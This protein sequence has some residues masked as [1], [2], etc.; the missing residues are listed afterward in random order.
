MMNNLNII[1]Y[2]I[3]IALIIHID[4]LNQ[5]IYVWLMFQKIFILMKMIIFIKNVTVNV[6]AAQNMEG[7]CK[8]ANM[9]IA[10]SMYQSYNDS[11]DVYSSLFVRIQC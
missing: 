10:K 6:K 7:D 8:K 4:Y 2:V 1:K 5:E 11:M 3:I 9:Y